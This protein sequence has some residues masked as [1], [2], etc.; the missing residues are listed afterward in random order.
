MNMRAVKGGDLED[1]GDVMVDLG[2]RVPKP[3]GDIVKD[4]AARNMDIATFLSL[5]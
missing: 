4:P 1:V 2:R 5:G 3:I